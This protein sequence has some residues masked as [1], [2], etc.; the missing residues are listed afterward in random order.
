MPKA[1]RAEDRKTHARQF[2]AHCVCVVGKNYRLQDIQLSKITPGESAPRNLTVVAELLPPDPLGSLTRGGP[3]TPLPASF[4][5][6]TCQRLKEGSHPPGLAR[7]LAA[8]LVASWGF[9]GSPA[10]RDRSM[11]SL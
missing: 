8:I 7:L 6:L 3:N 4:V 2:Y 9:Q 5:R 10:S 1:E 11:R